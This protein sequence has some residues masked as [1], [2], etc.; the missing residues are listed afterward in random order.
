VGVLIIDFIYYIN[1]SYF[2]LKDCLPII[3]SP[4]KRKSL[5]MLKNGYFKVE[6]LFFSKNWCPIQ[7][8]PNP[9]NGIAIKK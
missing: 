7:E 6:G 3:I 1:V 9:T 2:D 8:K 4:N 5:A